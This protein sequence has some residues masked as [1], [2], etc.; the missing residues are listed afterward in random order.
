MTLHSKIT[1]C[2]ETL[3]RYLT[4]FERWTKLFPTSDYS[5]LGACIKQTCVV[6]FSF[7]VDSIQFFR[8]STFGMCFYPRSNVALLIVR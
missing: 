3:S 4:L 1:N 5:E 6:F 8:R 7:I 2:L